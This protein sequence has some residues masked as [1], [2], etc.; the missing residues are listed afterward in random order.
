VV[1]TTVRCV[2]RV[3]GEVQG[4]GFRWWTRQQLARL[5]LS[6]SATNLDDGSVELVAHGDARAIDSLLAAISGPYAPG[7]VDSI[8]VDRSDRGA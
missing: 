2:A 5:G 3:R 4:V 1:T 6:G 7:R 8:E